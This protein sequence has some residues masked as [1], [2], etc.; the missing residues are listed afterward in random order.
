MLYFGLTLLLALFPGKL[1]DNVGKIITP[2]LI[3][4][5]VV[6]GA[7]PLLPAGTLSASLPDARAAAWP[8][9]E[10]FLQGYQT[11]DALASLIFGIVI[12]NAIKAAA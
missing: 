6:L 8:W 9:A 12:V 3:L 11:M 10:G 2:V 7:P 1:M 5:L 4:A